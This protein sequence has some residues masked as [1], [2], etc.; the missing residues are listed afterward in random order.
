MY[1][2]SLSLIRTFAKGKI[3]YLFSDIDEWLDNYEKRFLSNGKS[4][5]VFSLLFGTEMHVRKPFY[6]N[7]Q[8]ILIPR[9][10]SLESVNSIPKQLKKLLTH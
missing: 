7:A 8:L 3:N 10:K 6:L 9:F 4:E 1:K 2:N 5:T